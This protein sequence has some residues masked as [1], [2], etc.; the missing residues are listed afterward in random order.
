MSKAGFISRCVTIALALVAVSASSASAAVNFEWKVNSLF[1]KTGETRGFTLSPHSTFDLA[2]SVGGAPTL[3]L[4]TG[5]KVQAGAKILGGDP[6]TNEETIEFENITVDR[7]TGC[8]VSGGKITTVPLSSEIVEGTAGG[9]RGNEPDILFKSHEGTGS[10]ILATF[11]LVNNGAPC[12][13]GGVRTLTGSVL[14]LPL[15]RQTEVLSVLLD[16]E[17]V[18]KEYR[19][20]KSETKTAGLLLDGAVVSLKGAY[21]MTLTSD[22]KFNAF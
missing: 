16:F 9:A 22:E 11:E 15:P 7:P 3:I 4:S 12:G 6:G 21:L 13:I 14:A 8:A 19:N 2:G 17:A 10:T 1:L 5:V 18:T 20:T